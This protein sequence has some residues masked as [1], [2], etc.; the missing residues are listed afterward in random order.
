MR[1]YRRR[2]IGWLGALW[3]GAALAACGGAG[4]ER[5][6]SEGSTSAGGERASAIPSGPPPSYLAAGTKVVGRIDVARIRRSPLAPDIASALRS[7]AT[8]QALAGSSGLDPVQDLD[9]ILIGGDAVYTDRRVVVLRHPRTEAEVRDRILR[10][11]V[12]RGAQPV[13]RDLGGGLAATSWPMEGS[14]VPVSLVI[15]GE[16]ELVLAPDDELDRIASVARDHAARRQ[17]RDV[18]IEPHLADFRATEIGTFTFDVPLPAR[19][20]YPEPPARSR[21]ALDEGPT[22]EAM[23]SAHAEFD[24]EA[25]AIA[26]EQYVSQQ[27]QYW[28]QQMMVR[29]IGMHRPLEQARIVRQGEQ[30]D[31]ATSLTAEELRRA[32]G[33]MALSQLQGS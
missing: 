31:L 20:G 1:A 33:L 2:S 4:G 5:D 23:I 27:A 8:W 19:Q 30:L 25:Q 9:A 28:S 17:G 16:H 22:G 24:T 29:A 6:A 18:A 11:A 3:V 21:F 12:D 13:W 15:T 7:S 32:L 26:A 14:S 10:M